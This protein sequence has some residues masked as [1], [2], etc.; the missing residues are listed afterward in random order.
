[1]F[2]DLNP[3]AVLLRS[4][5]DLILRVHQQ[6]DM[7]GVKAQRM[8]Y[9]PIVPIVLHS[10]FHKMR[11]FSLPLSISTRRG[12]VIDDHR[13]RCKRTRTTPL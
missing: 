3:S 11:F 6:I 1:V 5:K 13:A 9:W 7:H 10:G 4:E 12:D 8:K 2:T